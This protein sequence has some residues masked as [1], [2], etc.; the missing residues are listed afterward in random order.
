MQHLSTNS[1]KQILKAIQNTN[2]N[3]LMAKFFI[4][5]PNAQAYEAIATFKCQFTTN[6]LDSEQFKV[7]TM[8]LVM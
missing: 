8:S 1:L 4:F 6:E 2:F 3:N 7:P 5:K